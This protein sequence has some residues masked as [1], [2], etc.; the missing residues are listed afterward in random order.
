[1]NENRKELTMSAAMKSI[2]E[3]PLR[4]DPAPTTPEPSTR[5][6]ILWQF[7]TRPVAR[8]DT[9]VLPGA[10]EASRPDTE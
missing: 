2:A 1:V 3:A 10:A 5:E 6:I 7:F 9:F 4:G 8:L